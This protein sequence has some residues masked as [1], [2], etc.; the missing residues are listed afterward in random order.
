MDKIQNLEKVMLNVGNQKENSSNNDIM[1]S[2]NSHKISIPSGNNNSMKE[3]S[4]KSNIQNQ[5]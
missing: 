3:E 4:P 1:N 2:F 5:S